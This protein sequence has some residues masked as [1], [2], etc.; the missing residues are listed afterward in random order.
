MTEQQPVQ[1]V[2]KK[3][4]WSAEET[5]P[6][7]CENLRTAWSEVY[8][9]ELGFN[10]NQLGLIRDV[11]VEP[12]RIIVKMILTTPFCPY[13][14]ALIEEIHQK[15]EEAIK[16]PVFIDLGMKPWDFSMMEEG[17]APNWGMY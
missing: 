10:V 12:E 8:D 3:L 9:P 11:T 2:A 15:A 7:L 14:S 4:V 13:G 16:Q 1:P 6:V 17:T 5:N